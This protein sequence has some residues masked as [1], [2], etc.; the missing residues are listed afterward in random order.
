MQVFSCT[1]PKD[2]SKP[3]HQRHQIDFS[4]TTRQKQKMEFHQFSTILTFLITLCTFIFSILILQTMIQPNRVETPNL[5]RKP[6]SNKSVVAAK[7][8][9]KSSKKNTKP[10]TV[11]N[12]VEFSDVRN[13]QLGEAELICSRYPGFRY[14]YESNRT[15]EQKLA[16]FHQFAQH[17]NTLTPSISELFME[18]CFK[19]KNTQN[20]YN[21]FLKTQLE[22]TEAVQ[23]ADQK[24]L[25]EKFYKTKT[26][27]TRTRIMVGLNREET[28]CGLKAYRS[29]EKGAGKEDLRCADFSTQIFR[30]FW[31]FFR[32]FKFSKF[33]IF[34]FFEFS[35][36]PDFQIF[37]LS[38][39]PN[40]QIFKIFGFSIFSNFQIFRIFDF[41]KFSVFQI[42]WFFDF[43]NLSDPAFFSKFHFFA[44]FLFST[45]GIFQQL[46]S[47]GEAT[48]S[49]AEGPGKRH[50]R[51]RSR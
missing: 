20:G 48:T 1:T 35:N 17:W 4:K 23:V 50:A 9:S 14:G 40:F 49:G 37:E 44:R 26:S 24:R 30:T 42:F 46:L 11:F 41:S 5:D 2:F 47:Q 7:S 43:S 27:P 38:N 32:I 12:K 22:F 6:V 13:L 45:S 36:F 16:F 51:Q 28:A 34:K 8:S 3:I 25:V 31:T 15:D 18:R 19:H 10:V 21:D 39:F 29:C 33:Q